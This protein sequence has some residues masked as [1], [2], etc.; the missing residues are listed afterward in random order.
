MIL[1]I[2]SASAPARVFAM[3]TGTEVQLGQE[4]DLQIVNSSVI[5]T[6]PLL[7][8]YVDGI[9]ENLWNQVARKDVPYSI[10]INRG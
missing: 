8:A 3:S 6:D 1:A 2:L 9:A 4:E 7:N 10:K 5:E